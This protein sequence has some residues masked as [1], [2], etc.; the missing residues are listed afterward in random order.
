MMTPV[1]EDQVWRLAV[2]RRLHDHVIQPLFG[3][4]LALG[5]SGPLDDRERSRCHAA[6]EAGLD[7]VRT[8]IAAVIGD[9][10]LGADDPAPSRVSEAAFERD[11]RGLERRFH[12]LP[13]RSVIR[14]KRALPSPVQG[15]ATHVIEEALRNARKH[16]VPTDVAVTI[17]VL[18]ECT[19]IEVINDGAPTPAV[20]GPCAGVG[21]KM[22]AAD[23]AAHRAVL[24]VDTPGRGLWRVR[25][26][27]PLM[28]GT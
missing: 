19:A 15:L 1:D 10:G 6:V 16:A 14:V 4:S 27:A 24:T 8:V 2:G 18:E 12:Q 25:L 21:L 5:A 3:V 23:A 17:D 26:L 7:E 22:L 28:G 20:G 11:M 9:R 13:V